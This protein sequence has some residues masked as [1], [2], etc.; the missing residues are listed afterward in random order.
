MVLAK[1][2]DIRNREIFFKKE[3]FKRKIKFLFIN[4]SN[5]N[6]KTEQNS[7][8]IYFF[9][10]LKNRKSSKTKL[11]RRCI[12]NNRSKGSLRSF[13]ISRILLREMFQFGIVPGYKKAVW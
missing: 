4:L 5:K 11:L 2:K 7:K 3:L 1:I 10:K 12:F 9:L 13:G 6:N 8:N